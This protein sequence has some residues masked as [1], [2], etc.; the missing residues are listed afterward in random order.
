MAILVFIAIL[1][2]LVLVHEFG[3][4]IIAKKSGMKVEEFGFGF[5][6]RIFGFR[7]G[8]TL[9][10]LNLIPL[11][12]F[13]KIVGENNSDHD[14][15]QSFIHKSFLARFGTLIAG[16]LMNVILAVVLLSI[17]FGMGLPTAVSPGQALPAHAHLEPQS[18][19]ILDVVAD[20]PASQAGMRGGDEII[21][22]DQKTFTDIVELSNYI[23]SRG[24]HEVDFNIKRG[25]QPLDFKVQARENPGPDQGAVG[26]AIGNIGILS[27]PWWYTPVA[28]AKATWQILVSTLSGFY[29]LIRGG[30]G[31]ASLGGPVKIASLTGQV[32]QLGF[33]Y[34][35]QFA[36]FLSINLAIL[37]V[38]PFPALDGGRILF[39]LIEKVRGKRNNPLIENWAN[40]IGFALLLILI[41]VITFHDIRGLIH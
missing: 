24:G 6:P 17:G 40:T 16:V 7:K 32:T 30:V 8:E 41:A 33:V 39:L 27:Y 14:D 38:M 11:G 9:Y 37:N 2:L 26:I 18:I 5:P 15:P 3:H 29:Q 28:G 12:G 4:F 22:V 1:A 10:S 31:F 35:L 36:A 23:K 13:V 25:N 21:S 20:S 19:S 34:V